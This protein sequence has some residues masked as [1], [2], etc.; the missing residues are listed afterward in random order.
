MGRR[1][2]PPPSTCC[3][4]GLPVNLRRTS[5]IAGP[6]DLKRNPITATRAS[7]SGTFSTARGSP[8]TTC[9]TGTCLSLEEVGD[10][11]QRLTQNTQGSDP[12]LQAATCKICV[13]VFCVACKIE[14]ISIILFPLYIV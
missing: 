11:R 10:Q 4:R 9:L 13:K 5:T 14:V 12:D 2:C 1:R 6:S 7:C 8:T 3:A